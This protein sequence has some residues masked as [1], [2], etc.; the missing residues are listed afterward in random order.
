MFF[1]HF[2]DGDPWQ[3]TSSASIGRIKKSRWLF[4]CFLCTHILPCVLFFSPTAARPFSSCVCVCS[5]TTLHNIVWHLWPLT[6]AGLLP[7]VLGCHLILRNETPLSVL[8]V[9]CATFP[10][11]N[12]WPGLFSHRYHTHTHTHTHL[13]LV[14]TCAI[15][16]ISLSSHFLD[17][18]TTSARRLQQPIIKPAVCDSFP[19][20]P[21]RSRWLIGSATSVLW[22]ARC[23]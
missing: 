10:S 23:T 13:F 3:M 1:F 18:A 12:D 11:S 22:T 21:H 4:C 20:P 15:S 9:A 6:L 7:I 8:Q 19:P 14:L 2:L 16:C 5:P 17:S